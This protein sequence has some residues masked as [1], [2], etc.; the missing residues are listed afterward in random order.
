MFQ[1]LQHS[2]NTHHAWIKEY[3]YRVCGANNIML[4][5][6]VIHDTKNVYNMY[7][8]LVRVYTYTYIYIYIYIC[9]HDIQFMSIQNAYTMSMECLV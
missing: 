8:F 3:L 7:Y 6:V 4:Y 2:S 9:M 1:R 5:F